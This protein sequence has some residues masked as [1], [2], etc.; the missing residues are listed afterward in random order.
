MQNGS[1]EAG[2]CA[3]FMDK[4]DQA[5]REVSKGYCIPNVILFYH[6]IKAVSQNI[7]FW[8]V[9]IY[10]FPTAEPDRYNAPNQFIFWEL[11]RAHVSFRFG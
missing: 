10:Y 4:M 8:C 6:W 1:H 5:A 11:C 7:F 3:S 2:K 9:I